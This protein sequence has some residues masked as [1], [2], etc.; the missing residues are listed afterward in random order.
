MRRCRIARCSWSFERQATRSPRFGAIRTEIR[1]LDPNLPIPEFRTLDQV[2]ADSLDRPRF[3]TTLL[4]L[5]SAVALTLAAVGIFGL[6]SF[7][8]A[9]RTREIGVRIALG[10]S[11]GI[12]G[13]NGCPRRVGA[14]RHRPR[15]SVLREHSR[16]RAC[17]KASC[18][19]IGAADPVT[20]RRRYRDAGSHGVVGKPRPC[21]ASVDGRPVGGAPS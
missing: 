12:T 4:S 18:S 7:A 21:L 5:F 16:S 19:T 8:V 6:L 13:R 9:R 2:V 1:A 11:P 15:L 20:V 14:R 10:A 3:F 17:W